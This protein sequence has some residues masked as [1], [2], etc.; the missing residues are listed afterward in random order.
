MLVRFFIF[1][2]MAQ[3]HVQVEHRYV[4][5]AGLDGFGPQ[6][7]L[8]QT[9]HGRIN[10]LIY[11]D[12]GQVSVDSEVERQADDSRAITRLALH[13]AQPCHLKQL[14]PYR[15]H[16]RLLQFTCGDV[17]AAHLNRNLRNGNVGQERDR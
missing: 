15:S 11:F 1:W 7:L 4:G 16:H 8:G 2:R 17:F 3:G 10:F 13:L 5:G 12:E 6:S 9:V 14:A